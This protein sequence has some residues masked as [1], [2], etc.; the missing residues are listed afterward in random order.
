[1]EDQNS[2]SKVIFKNTGI[3]IRGW[4][5]LRISKFL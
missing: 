5:S 1:M 4:K 3:L 2:Y